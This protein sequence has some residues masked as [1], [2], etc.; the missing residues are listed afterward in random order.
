MDARPVVNEN[1]LSI[2]TKLRR[3]GH[4]MTSGEI[5]DV[6]EEEMPLAAVEYHLSTLVKVG[7]AQPLFGPE[8]Y[9]QHVSQGAVPSALT[10]SKRTEP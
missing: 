10:E 4:P 3:T 6:L 2:A 9:F 7:V 5:R 1:K 8:I